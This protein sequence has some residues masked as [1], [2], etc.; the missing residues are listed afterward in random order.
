MS[1]MHD[2][3]GDA[4]AYV[5]GALD[6]QEAVAFTRHMAGCIVCR[7]E[8]AALQQVSSALAMAATQYE[9][10]RQLRKQVMSA[11]RAEPRMA[12][13]PARR[14]WSLALPR[15][16]FRP[17]LAAGFAAVIAAVV[18]AG[19]LLSSGGSGGVRVYKASVGQA[20]VRVS[21]ARAELIVQ[22]LP[23]PPAGKIYEVWLGRA[24]RPPAPTSTLFSVTRSGRGDVGLPGNLRGVDEILVT[25]EPAGGSQAP[26]HTPVIVTP[27]T[28]SD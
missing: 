21:G 13:A 8:V 18:L 22:R 27:L 20:E 1:E 17:A 3:G 28:K 25:P 23:A 5:L 4:A 10:P 6:E 19:V 26:T 12:P 11:V 2:C 24:G 7:D 9:A 14:Q 16:V 15:L